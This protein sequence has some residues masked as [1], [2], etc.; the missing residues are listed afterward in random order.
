MPVSAC[1]KGS[2]A[3]SYEL[4]G[5]FSIFLLPTIGRTWRSLTQKSSGLVS[6]T[7]SIVV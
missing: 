3:A 7:N 1:S 5:T 4:M 2:A 6:R